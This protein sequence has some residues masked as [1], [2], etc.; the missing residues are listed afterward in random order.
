MQV[1]FVNYIKSGVLLLLFISVLNLSGCCKRQ[2]MTKADE[3]MSA[4]WSAQDNYGKKITLSFN[5]NKA[6]IK[7]E[8]KDFTGKIYGMVTL[9]DDTL[10]IA[11][12]ALN[13]NYVFKYVLFGNK[14]DL[15]YGEK[16]IELKKI[17]K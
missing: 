3:L 4:S 7:L 13:E 9:S 10:E 11:D 12:K 6:L 1:I 2:I 14:I 8:T 17:T 15:K 16:T 5:Q